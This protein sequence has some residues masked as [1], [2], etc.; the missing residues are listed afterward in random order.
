MAWP[1][2]W[3]GANFEFGC[4]AA[5]KPAAG[6]EII[7]GRA[8]TMN[9]NL[10][11]VR[12]QLELVLQRHVLPNVEPVPPWVLDCCRLALDGL[13]G[14]LEDREDVCGQCGAQVQ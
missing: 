11:Y 10:L 12:T 4:L 7:Y 3:C 8:I 13:E 1:E 9:V 6:R 5:D 2:L 14:V